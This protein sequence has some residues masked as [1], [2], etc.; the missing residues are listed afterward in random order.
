ML[1]FKEFERLDIFYEDMI[2]NGGLADDATSKISNFLG[3]PKVLLVSDQVK[4]NS[5]NLEDIVDNY[6]DLK[7]WLENTKYKNWLYED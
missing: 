3:I 4:I 6:T 2:G 7:R 1:K 5:K